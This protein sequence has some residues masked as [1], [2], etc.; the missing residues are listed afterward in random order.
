[1]VTPAF[2]DSVK[3]NEDELSQIY[4]FDL[5]F[6]ETAEEI[7]RALTNVEASMGDEDGL[8]TA[9]RHLTTLAREAVTTFEHR[10]EMINGSG[11]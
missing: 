4:Q 2:L 7:E 8:K 10:Y 3:I 9:I 5:S 1:M 6:F 11:K